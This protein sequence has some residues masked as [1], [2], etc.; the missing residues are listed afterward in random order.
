MHS[1]HV[2]LML[3]QRAHLQG[4]VC[5]PL[6]SMCNPCPHLRHVKFEGGDRL[7]ELFSLIILLLQVVL[8]RPQRAMGLLE[9]F[10]LVEQL[11]LQ[12]LGRVPPRGFELPS[13]LL[14]FLHVPVLFLSGRPSLK[15]LTGLELQ[16]INSED[17]L[18]PRQGRH[19]KRLLAHGRR[20]IAL[21][22][23]VTTSK[24]IRDLTSCLNIFSPCC[25]ASLTSTV[26]GQLF[27]LLS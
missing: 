22:L 11:E 1:R 24:T 26:P 27:P 18:A 10:L 3:P 23:P 14:Q 15:E 6:L 19:L 20:V 13:S 5:S 9:P 2:L 25:L 17:K 16:R 8:L 21:P 12:L 4:Q 7:G